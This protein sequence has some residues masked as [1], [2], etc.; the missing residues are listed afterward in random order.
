MSLPAALFL[1]LTWG[2][3]LGLAGVCC[4]RVLTLRRHPP[5]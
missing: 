3:I 4:W 2:A 5:R 1:V